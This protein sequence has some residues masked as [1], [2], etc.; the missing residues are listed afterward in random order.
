MVRISPAIKEE[1]SFNCQQLEK[2]F[3]NVVD[4]HK[5]SVYKKEMSLIKRRIENALLLLKEAKNII[6]E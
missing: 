4:D 1:L 5:N 6:G 2:L 3:K